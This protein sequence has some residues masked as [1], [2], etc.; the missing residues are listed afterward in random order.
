[1]YKPQKNYCL[2][3]DRI[4][5]FCL[6]VICYLFMVVFLSLGSRLGTQPPVAQ[7]KNMIVN[8]LENQC[9]LVERKFFFRKHS[10]ACVWQATVL[11]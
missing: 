1:M 4:F 5:L 8:S 6:F 3:L 11:F 2:A 10:Y 7:D 9:F